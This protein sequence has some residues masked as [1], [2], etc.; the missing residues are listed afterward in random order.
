MK[1][2]LIGVIAGNNSEFITYME[3]LIATEVKFRRGFTL[4][5]QAELKAQ[6]YCIT[7]FPHIA[8]VPF[9][10]VIT[11]GTGH[12]LGDYEYM[13]L[14]AEGNIVQ[15]VEQTV[16]QPAMA[17][18]INIATAICHLQAHNAGW[19]DKSREVGT[20]IALMHSELSEAMEGARKDMQ[21]EHLPHRK[22]L[23]VELADTV[24]RILDFAGYHGLDIGGA[25]VEKLAY[26]AKRIDHT[27]EARAATHG[28]AF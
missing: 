10:S 2:A 28:K 1:Q 12:K 17:E 24:I 13:L 9:S 26:N 18:G 3:D 8:S 21:D 15:T 19:W 23:E 27:P 11:I 6:Y 5:H 14:A 4:V 20:L 25:M 22:S 7:R 16:V